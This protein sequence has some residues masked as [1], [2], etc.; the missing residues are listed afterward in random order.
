MKKWI[1]LLLSVCLFSVVLAQEETE[2]D[3]LLASD[4]NKDGVINIL[5]LVYVASQYGEI[6][7]EEQRP[8]PDVNGDGDINILDLEMIASHF[9]KYSG[10]PLEIT[11]KTFDTTVSN[12]SLPILVEFHSDY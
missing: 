12:A 2:Y 11:D 4:V 6:L 9:G 5:D 10:I 3:S 1:C 8:N 7:E